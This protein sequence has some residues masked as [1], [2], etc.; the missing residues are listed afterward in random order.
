MMARICQLTPERF[1]EIIDDLSSPD[2]YS[3][4]SEHNGRRV[5]KV[6]GG[7][8]VLNYERYRDMKTRAMTAAERKRRQRERELADQLVA[9]SHAGHESHNVTPDTDTDEDEKQ[10]NKRPCS[11]AVNG[12]AGFDEFWDAY[13][14][15][16]AKKDA[17][18]A[19][20][21][22]A[23]GRPE[24]PELLSVLEKHKQSRQWRDSVIPLPATWL[25][26]ER[27]GDEMQAAPDEGESDRRYQRLN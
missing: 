4:S 3:R 16:Q 27:W 7:Y 17:R 23:K 8:V 10:K 26:G 13:P 19:W 24:L 1:E 6:E 25:R 21:T 11:P 22:T 14:R 15:K 12:G 2:P 5:Q 18:K 9:A 20:Q